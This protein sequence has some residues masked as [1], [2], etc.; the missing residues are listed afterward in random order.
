MTRTSRA[1]L[2]NLG[3]VALLVAGNPADYAAQG[4]QASTQ[5]PTQVSVAVPPGPQ[6]PMPPTR[7]GLGPQT[8]PLAPMAVS[9]LEEARRPDAF[10]QTLSLS[11]AEPIAVRELLLMLVR[12]TDLSVVT[13]PDVDGTFTGELKNV[14]LRHALDLILRPLD[15]EPRISEHVLRVSKRQMITR[16]FDINYVAARRMGGGFGGGFGMMGGFNGGFGGGMGGGLGYGGA[17]YG[18][19]GG[20][21]G[22]YNGYGSGFGANQGAGDVFDEISTGLQTLL[23]GDG[24]HNL[25]R[26]AGLLQVTDYP[27]VLDKIAIYL[28]TYETRALRQVHIMA[29]VIEVEMREEFSAGIDWGTVFRSAGNTVSVTQ[30]LAPTRGGSAFT[31]GVNIR[32]FQGLLEAFASQGKVN[33]MASPYV[34]AMNNEPAVMR[35]GT[36]DVFFVTTSQVDAGS[37]TLLQTSVVPQTVTEG[38]MLNVTPQIS[39]D[40]IIHLSITP[41]IT[42]RTGTATS[43]LGDQV[44]I[45]SVRETD[46]LVR[47]HEGETIV[48]A[49]LMQ[50]RAMVDKAKVP[51][52]GDVP[53]IGGLFRREERSK[54]K[55]DLVILLTPTMM[56]P[57]ELAANAAADQQ[58]VYEEQRKPARK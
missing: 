9:Q 44:P 23:S 53:V 7:Q 22:G 30:Q 31:M 8:P 48:I 13:D 33:V 35:V 16:I 26:K 38:I 45:V 58:R 56:S 10:E 32:D 12:D 20:G 18:G 3:I 39:A 57:G 2:L 51:V 4:G 21:M 46:T 29:K 24:R 49:G 41:T 1:T 43:R 55:T 47:V 54:R 5:G 36:Q 37:G 19:F 40:G 50:E 11:F 15:L 52:L 17:G 25:D 14:T 6:D 42:E 28:E 34:M 27:E